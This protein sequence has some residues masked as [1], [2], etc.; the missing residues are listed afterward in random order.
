VTGQVT[1]QVTARAGRS[2][3]TSVRG[4]VAALVALVSLVTLMLVAAPLV[5]DHVR[6]PAVDPVGYVVAHVDPDTRAA[7]RGSPTVTPLPPRETITVVS[8]SEGLAGETVASLAGLEGVVATTLV[9]SGVTGL[10]GSSDADGVARDVLPPGHRIPVTVTAIDPD[11]YGATLVAIGDEAAGLVAGLAPGRVLL[12]VSSAA[13]RGIGVGGSVDLGELDGLEVAG[14]V[15]DR[16][17]R[18]SEFLVHLDD[19]DG[20]G[21][22]RRESLLLRHEAGGEL[23]AGAL[24]DLGEELRVWHDGEQVR[25]VL[26]QVE[27]KSRFGEFSFRPIP[28]QRE[29]VIDRAFEAQHITIERMPVL[30]NVRC[31]RLVMA[32]LR[33]ALEEVVEA[34]LE[35]WLDP[36]GFG[37]CF[38]ARRIGFGR[39]S[40]SRHSWG[41]AIDLN[42]DFSLPGSGPV[43]P[44]AFIGIMGQHGFRWGGDF[45]TPD[46]HHFE[47]VGEA[48]RVRPTRG[49]A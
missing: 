34:G 29:V 49:G 4:T 39:E 32:D 10:F 1:G 18:G 26:S 46:N 11:G 43:P 38:H 33:A 6:G 20:V 8:A 22:G 48:A 14:I 5:E 36:R 9:R 2:R 23:L 41:V 24:A 47:W 15:D 25:L 37:G 45:A 27:L 40:L 17:A 28:G 16:T 7:L 30:G 12:S 21:L 35:E 19:A 13:L 31:H 42:V 44:D 3:A